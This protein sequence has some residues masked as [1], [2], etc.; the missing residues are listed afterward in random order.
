MNNLLAV[1][2]DQELLSRPNASVERDADGII[3]RITVQVCKRCR[4]SVPTGLIDPTKK[5]CKCIPPVTSTEHVIWEPADT[6][7]E[8][9]EEDQYLSHATEENYLHDLANPL[10]PMTPEQQEDFDEAERDGREDGGLWH[11]I[12]V[13]KGMPVLNPLA[14]HGIAGSIIEKLSA[15]TEAHPVGLLIGIL[16]QFGSMCGESAH[17]MVEDQP[18]YASFNS[19]KVGE[20]SR[21][22]KG[23]AGGRL[24]AFMP[25]IDPEWFEN[26]QANNLSSGEGLADRVRDAYT[27]TIKGVTKTIDGVADKRLY[28]Y[29]GE[30]GQVLTAMAR[31]GSTL[32]ATIRNLTDHQPIGGLTK[33]D[34]TVC[35]NPHISIAMDVTKDEL[36]KELSRVECMNGFGNR[37]LIYLVHRWNILPSG[38]ATVDLTPEIEV[39]KTRLRRAK[40]AGCMSRDT[41][42]DRVWKNFYKHLPDTKGIVGA[43][44]ARAE[45]FVTGI[46]MIYALLDSARCIRREHLRAAIAIWDYAAESVQWIFGGFNGDQANLLAYMEEEGVGAQYLK[47]GSEGP[48]QTVSIRDIQRAVF[49]GRSNVD[50]IQ[51]HVDAL[52][53][54]RYIKTHQIDGKTRY[55]RDWRTKRP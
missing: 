13:P 51:E 27:I 42:A 12:E 35:K 24:R 18:V 7:A 54:K 46:A 37:F 55:S 5:V 8:I 16:Q 52:I 38:G 49:G 30:A 26:C 11:N 14:L 36:I 40:S 29:E 32:S 15:N 4:Q 44:C 53:A 9:A 41:E 47:D 34:K 43:M 48:L 31:E 19:L 25:L 45:R 3:T 20:T 10:P 2:P 33:H 50:V 28:V 21:S 1:Q 17:V 22:R 6:L 23:T 39:L